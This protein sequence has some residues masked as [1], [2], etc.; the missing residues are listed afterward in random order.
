MGDHTR[1]R[2]RLTITS[3][4]ISSMK[5]GMWSRL[6]QMIPNWF[7]PMRQ[8]NGILGYNLTWLKISGNRHISV[9][10]WM[11]RRMKL[12]SNEIKYF[13]NFCW[14][15]MLFLIIRIIFFFKFTNNKSNKASNSME[16]FSKLNAI[17][18]DFLEIRPQSF[19]FYLYGLF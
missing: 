19:L 9:W 1:T 16:V 15:D 6:K 10:M 18:K 11:L 13:M 4:P 17:A 7:L 5:M 2:N 3:R 12:L 14:M 8:E